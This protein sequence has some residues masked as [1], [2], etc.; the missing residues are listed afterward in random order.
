[1][2]GW[3]RQL[4]GEGN[5]LAESTL[6][7]DYAVHASWLGQLR[8]KILDVGGGAGL[9]ARYLHPSC[10]YTVL[11]PSP[12]WNEPDWKALSERF[13]AGH[14]VQFVEG[15]GEAMPFADNGFDVVVAF[16]SLN[17]A[18]CPDR[19]LAEMARVLR[20]GGTALLVLEDMK[21]GWRDLARRA[22]DGAM[23]RVLRVPVTRFWRQPEVGGVAATLRH[24][25]TGKPWPLQNDH[26][27]I[28]EADLK[29]WFSD[30]F[31]VSRREWLGGYLTFELIRRK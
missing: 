24:L 13:R 6:H 27:R 29:R 30:G 3:Y 12:V 10:Q 2:E 17:H 21:P 15:C 25:I 9:T 16:W 14:A 31:A 23:A 22:W 1:M 7:N 4:L 19:C 5:T 26:V 18:Q 8:G 20:P 11:D 28:D